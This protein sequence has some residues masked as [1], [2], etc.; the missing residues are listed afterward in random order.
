MHRQQFQRH[1]LPQPV[2]TPRETPPPTRWM[3]PDFLHRILI[4]VLAAFALSG[5]EQLRVESIPAGEVVACD[6]AF[7][8][9]WRVEA[10]SPGIDHADTLHLHVSDDCAQWITV[11]TDADGQR[12]QDDVATQMR[13]EFRRIGE[14]GYLALSD[15][16]NN[17]DDKHEV[18]D[19][20]VLLRYVVRADRIDLFEGDPRREAHRVGEGLVAGKVESGAHAQCGTDGN[21]NV[22]TTI[23]GDG[24]AIAEWLRRFDP[25]DRAFVEL[26][27]IDESLATELDPLLNLPPATGKPK[28]HE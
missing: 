25:I 21:C 19:G 5:C 20:Y 26:R 27:R 7:G 2:G 18:G 11:E 10:E 28:P 14:D 9:W 16:P 13:F 22:N 12:T 17:P 8:G 15:V 24:H 4:A 3:H 6:Q 23:T 1:R